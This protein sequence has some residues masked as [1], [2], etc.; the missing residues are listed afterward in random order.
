MTDKN[1][2]L[3]GGGSKARIIEAMIAEQNFGRVGMIFDETLNNL[4]FSSGLAFSSNVEELAASLDSFTNFVVCVGGPNGL[5]RVEIAKC[6]ANTGLET[7]SLVHSTAFID[8]TS[9]V[10]EGAQ[11]MPSATVHKF[12]ELGDQLIVN[13]NA[14]IDHETK[15]GNGVHIMGGA[16]IAG[17]VE[18]GDY[19]SVGTNA[20]V[21]PDI[22]IGEGAYVGAGAVVTK[23]VPAYSVSAG[24][25]ARHLKEN[26]M[27]VYT[28][29]LDY[30]SKNFAS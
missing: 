15:I 28:E 3:W 30:I 13:T 25:P 20:T 19:A 10:G 23:N 5:A 21:L 16:A 24:V 29:T 17:R 22:V 9:T 8:P 12:C 1:I 2:L 7:L 26:A 6:L 11:I 27:K 4:P 18:I 14:T